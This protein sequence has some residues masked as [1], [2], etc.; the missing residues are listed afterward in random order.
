MED[1]HSSTRINVEIYVLM[2]GEDVATLGPQE[3]TKTHQLFDRAK[4]SDRALLLFIDE[5]NA[6]LCE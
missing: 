6:F 2:T 5:A 4:K 1:L 3:V